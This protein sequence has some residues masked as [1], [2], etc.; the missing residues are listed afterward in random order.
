[1]TEL[2]GFERNRS[3]SMKSDKLELHR[4]ILELALLERL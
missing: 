1:M 3:G 4:L 2:E